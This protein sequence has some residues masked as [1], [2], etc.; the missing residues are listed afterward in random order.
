M[1]IRGMGRANGRSRSVALATNAGRL[2]LLAWYALSLACGCPT[3]PGERVPAL[4]E[5]PALPE[6]P[7]IRPRAPAAEGFD[8]GAPPAPGDGVDVLDTSVL[9]GG[10]DAS[11]TPEMGTLTGDGPES[12]P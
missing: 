3:L 7:G 9:Y 10:L 4:L 5:G 8:A 6:G 2:Y 1:R 12:S 11:S